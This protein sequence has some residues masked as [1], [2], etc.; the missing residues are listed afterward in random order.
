M[1]KCII[2][3]KMENLVP[4]C[5][6]GTKCYENEEDLAK[7]KFICKECLKSGES[8][9]GQ[10]PLCSEDVAYNLSDLIGRYGVNACKEHIDEFDDNDD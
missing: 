2:C 6:K 8:A 1:V 10:C 9:Y 5:K 7:G 4:V 3:G